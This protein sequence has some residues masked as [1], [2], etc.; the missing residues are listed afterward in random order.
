MNF[1]S[2][3][4]SGEEKI[5]EES[6]FTESSE[7]GRLPPTISLESRTVATLATS[8]IS[9]TVGTANSQGWWCQEEL[10]FFTYQ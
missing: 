1:D 6:A 4:S 10:K 2:F 9:N 7:K 3:S 8:A 5:E